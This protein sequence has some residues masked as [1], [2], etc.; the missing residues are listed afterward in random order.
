MQKTSLLKL[1]VLLNGFDAKARAQ[2]LNELV[3]LAKRGDVALEPEKDVA[4]MHAHTFFSFNAY[5]YSPSALAW[6]AKT[7]GYRLMGI[8]DF[9]VLDGVDEFLN[10]C[11][12]LGVRGSAGMETRVSIPEFASR[13]INSPGEP[14]I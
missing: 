6:L 7:Q 10:A 4:N 11:E 9:D 14:G 1:E 3:L 13:E 2:S 12:L 8:V 5:G